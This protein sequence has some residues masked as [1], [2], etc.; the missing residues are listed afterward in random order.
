[1]TSC[2]IK[3]F[4]KSFNVFFEIMDFLETSDVTKLQGMNKKIY[5]HIAPYVTREANLRLKLNQDPTTLY[6]F[7]RGTLVA[8]DLQT[9]IT[10]DNLAE[11]EWRII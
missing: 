2:K 1:M 5:E 10:N 3:L 9:G 6:N 7:N 8:L 11:P 4:K